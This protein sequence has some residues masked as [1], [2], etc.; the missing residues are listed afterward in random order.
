MS[1]RLKPILPDYLRHLGSDE[2]MLGLL[3]ATYGFSAMV[4]SPIFGRLSDIGQNSRQVVLV[5]LFFSI[6]GHAVT[7][8]YIF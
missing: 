6:F 8:F 5:A 3:V 1:H 4:F 7:I 2:S